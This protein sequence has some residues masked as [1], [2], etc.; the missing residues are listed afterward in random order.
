MG[1]LGKE[2]ILCKKR[3]FVGKKN[4]IISFRFSISEVHSDSI[5]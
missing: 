5:Q 2:C 4:C 1:G 3:I